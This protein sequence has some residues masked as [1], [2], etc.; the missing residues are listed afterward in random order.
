MIRLRGLAKRYGDTEAVR[1]LDLDIPTG[2]LLGLLGPNGAGK[3]TTLKMLTGML[4]PTAGTADVF[5]HDVVRDAVEVKRIVGY[6]PESGAVFSTLT[7]WEYLELVAALHQ[8]P[9]AETAVLVRR[10][11]EFFELTEDTLR[12]EQLSA[13]SKGMRQKVV[14]TAA[15]LHNPKAVFFDEPLNGLDA[16]ATLAFKTLITS[17]ARDGKTIV[18]CSHLLDVVERVCER[19]VI[20]REGRVIA[21]GSLAALRERTG[22]TSL[23]RIFNELTATED[24]TARAEEFARGLVR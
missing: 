15:L 11:A 5:G 3:S 4:V 23:E 24:L 12:R 1:G 7:G 9:A 20:V 14:I 6:V 19:I 18:Y 16:N 21:D 22:E 10:F 8:L 2:Q 17:L 13:Y